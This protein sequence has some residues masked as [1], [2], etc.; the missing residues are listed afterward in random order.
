[1]RRKKKAKDE[2]KMKHEAVLSQ[3]S[4]YNR[5]NIEDKDV[6]REVWQRFIDIQEQIIKQRCSPI[7]IDV[8]S[9]EI[10]NDKLYVTVD[11]TQKEQQLDSIFTNQLGAESYD[12]TKGTVLVS[13]KKW[14]S[15]SPCDLSIIRKTLSENYIELNTT[16]SINAEIDYGYGI[17]RSDQ[18]SLDELRQ[19]NATINQGDLIEGSIDNT[20]AFISKVTVLREDLLK[21]LFGSHYAVYEETSHK[22]EVPKIIEQ[23]EYHNQY[24]TWE[25]YQ[26]YQ[27]IGLLCKQYTLIFKIHNQNAQEELKECFDCWR[28]NTE[29][30]E[31]KRAFTRKSPF[32]RDFLVEINENIQQFV[33][34]A[35]L[36]C[37]Q[38][39]IEINVDFVYSVSNYKL[40]MQKFQEVAN[41]IAGREGYS[42]NAETGAIGIDFNW[43]ED[44]IRSL[45]HEIEE[46]VPFININIFDNHRFKC[47]VKTQIVGFEKLKH[48]LEDVYAN[49]VVNNDSIDHKVSIH[50][51]YTDEESYVR[52]ESH[53]QRYLQQ[54]AISG[55]KVKI[56]PKIEGRIRLNFI[57]DNASKLEDIEER[58]A[59][60]RKAD[61]GF[62]MGD[63]EIVFGKLLKTKYPN[64]VFDID[65]E[66]SEKE[67]II[68]AFESKAVNTI[69]PILT[70]DLE[71]ISR[72]KDTF[73]KATTGSELANPR[74]Q[75]FIFDSSY[76]TK[77]KD[78][79][80]YLR[81]DGYTY[82][83]LCQHL[84]NPSIN[85]SQKEAI[86]KAIYADDLAVIQGPPGT[87]KS[88]AIAEL[89]WQLIRIGFKQGCPRERILITSET[90]LAVD[91]ALSRIV[92]SKTN[93]VRPIRFGGEEKL[94]SEGLQ[95]SIDLMK[96]WVEEGDSCLVS[97]DTDEESGNS[98]RTDLI[99]KNWLNNI[100]LRSFYGDTDPNNQ[101][102]TRWHNYLQGH[103]KALREVVYTN[104]VD[105]ANVIGATC[106]SIGEKK[107]GNAEFNGFTQ[108]YKN[109]CEIFKQ[110]KGRA[111]IEFTTVIQDESS[112]ATP[113]ELVLPF[114]YGRKAIV[115][116]DH[117]QLPPMLDKEEFE[118]TLELALK[119]ARNDDEKKKIR[120]LQTFVIEHFDEMEISHFQ[121]LYEN[122]DESLKCTFH[123]QYRM[124]PAINEVIEQFYREDGGLR[125]GLITPKDLGIDDH[126]FSNPASRYHGLDIKGLVGHNT[127]VL[128]I[129]TNSPEM[130]DG[131]SRVNY[132]EVETVDKI[133]SKFEQSSTFQRYLA[134][135][136]KEEDKQ[137]GIISFYGKQIKQLRSVAYNHR[138]LPLRVSTVDRFQGMERNIVIV[139]MVRS[140]TIQSSRDQKPDWKHYPLL[141]YPSQKSLGFAQSPN[142]L[143]VALSRAKRLL[144]I[145]GNQELFSKLDI[146]QRL[147]AIIKAN[148]NNR[149][150]K[151]EDV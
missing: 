25:N 14:N 38:E 92:N 125:C 19:L 126:N 106:S 84:L 26:E 56:E 140:N 136:A 82:K 81:Q 124:H 98:R 16:P 32:Q 4:N 64:L 138:S 100:S 142:R 10:D 109:Y 86:I 117:R 150:I 110:K 58:I 12:L 143:N 27:D 9:I 90:N 101:V 69:V 75:R 80:N 99:L 43:R 3:E 129:D 1:M 113:A 30:F 121:K 13:E 66:D 45:I 5:S 61:F 7:N 71:K 6:I 55:I 37:P 137:I 2:R 60:M 73:T 39:D 44:D 29:T 42:F 127:H 139:S 147:F 34:E 145:V 97:E 49:I 52:L 105:H 116:G 70:G 89:I 57:Y 8:S 74:L 50:L 46:K 23:F 85:E 123:L 112:K 53:L 144:I 41:V 122:I 72:L 93:L 96:R 15:L 119:S 22:Q 95:F 87:G 40:R 17:G 35:S 134:K 24:I 36:Y 65:V 20:A 11:E 111:K 135:F 31:F 18:M 88:T 120:N 151:Q 63:Q 83:D 77:T 94:E 104:Y 33:E 78:I 79:G 47:N 103:D 114:V 59:G 141:G 48:G 68:E 146:Y 21:H 148:K 62:I 54:I 28:P 115:I 133:L 149:V 51:P 67:R 107:A 132:G 76:A 91:N 131:T 118:D 108:F 102:V 130:M 128:F